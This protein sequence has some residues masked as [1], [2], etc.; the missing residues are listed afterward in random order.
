MEDQ[1][2]S[3]LLPLLACP[4]DRGVLQPSADG[5]T[6]TCTVCGQTYRIVDGIPDLRPPKSPRIAKRSN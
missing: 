1:P 2:L 4:L 3:A 5:C 6:L